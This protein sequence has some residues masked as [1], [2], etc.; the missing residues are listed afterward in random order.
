AGIASMGPR[1]I[2]R[3]NVTWRRRRPSVARASM[4]PRLISRGNTAGGGAGG[5]A[6]VLQWGRG[7]SAAEMWVQHA[8]G[9]VGPGFNGAAAHQPRKWWT[10]NRTLIGT[11]C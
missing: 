7:S 10:V 2:S 1:L 4:G 8:G 3:G 11:I 5:N 6:T 9:V